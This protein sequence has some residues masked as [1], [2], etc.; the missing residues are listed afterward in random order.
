MPAQCDEYLIILIKILTIKFDPSMIASLIGQT[1]TCPYN[2][3]SCFDKSSVFLYFNNKLKLF[4]TRNYL[5]C[6]SDI[7]VVC[8]R[9]T[10]YCQKIEIISAQIM[11][12]FFGMCDFRTEKKWTI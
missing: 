10:S 5:R 3:L 1:K 12:W 9:S 7:T 6:D 4:S 2:R 8:S 11:H